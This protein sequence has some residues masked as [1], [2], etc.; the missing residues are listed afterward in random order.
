VEDERGVLAA[1]ETDHPRPVV[2]LEV[3]VAE[4]AAEGVEFL[5]EVGHGGIAVV[6]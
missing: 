6:F 3:F 1:G 5:G 4:F 2:R